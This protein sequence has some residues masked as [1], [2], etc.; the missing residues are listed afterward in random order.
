ML[1]AHRDDLRLSISG[2]DVRDFASQ[3]QQ[4]SVVLSLKLAEGDV[5]EDICGEAP[6]YLFDD[7]LSE[8]D[9]KRR[10]YILSSQ[11]GRQMI[12][13]SCEKDLFREAHPIHVSDGTFH[14]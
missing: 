12:V 14:V 3:G 1:G 2:V 5:S 4:R 13:T 11:D 9:E 10:R 6:V 8:L 7:V